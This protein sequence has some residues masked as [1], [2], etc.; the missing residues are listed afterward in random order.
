MD[1]TWPCVYEMLSLVKEKELSTP[2][3]AAGA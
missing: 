2:E 3:G 1:H